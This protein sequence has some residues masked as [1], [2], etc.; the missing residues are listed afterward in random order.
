MRGAIL[1]SPGRAPR[2]APAATFLA[3][4]RKVAKA[5]AHLRSP[6]YF[7]SDTY[8]RTQGVWK[9]FWQRADLKWHGYEPLAEVA[10]I[11]DFLEAVDKDEYHC[12]WG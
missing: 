10:A 12:F 7:C 9:I 5:R 1:L 4:L 3:R 2:P 6:H 11:E 8:V